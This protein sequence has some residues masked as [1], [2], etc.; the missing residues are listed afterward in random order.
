MTSPVSIGDAYLLGSL[1][2]KLGRAFTKGQRSAPAEFREVENLL[3]SLSA[4]LC[5]LKDSSAVDKSLWP[6]GSSRL[7]KLFTRTRPNP[8]ENVLQSMLQNCDETLK[9]LET[10][11]EKY[12]CLGDTRDPT[13]SPIRRWSRDLR[14]NWKKVEWTTEGGDLETLR[15]QLTVHTNSLNLI[16][17]VLNKSV[18]QSPPT[19]L[20]TGAACDTGCNTDICSAAPSPSGSIIASRRCR[21]C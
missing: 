16:L 11:V 2:L 10:I 21:P 15:S 18:S 6:N 12:G 5:A 1:A 19:A 8:N 20:R 14:R 7:S 17:G 13:A 9:H 4:A 3:Y